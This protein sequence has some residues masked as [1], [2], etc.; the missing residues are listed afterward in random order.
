MREADDCPNYLRDFLNYI[1]IV[2]NLGERTTLAYYTDLRCFLRYLKIKNGLADESSKWEEISISDVPFE[3]VKAVDLYSAYTYLRWL[4]AKRNNS[5]ATRARKTT[6][7]REFYRY[8]TKK[9]HLLEKDPLEQLEMPAK[10]EKLPKFLTLE[11][12]KRLL[13][14]IESSSAERDFCIMVLFL[15][16][17]LRLSELCGL[18]IG[19]I[20]FDNK[21][22]R[23]LGKGNK[24]RI[25][26][27]NDAC[28]DSIRRYLEVRPESQT[29]ALFLSNRK[30]RLSRRRVQELTEKYVNAAGLGNRGISTHKLRHTAATLMYQHGGCDA[31]II[32]DILGHKSIATTEIYTHLANENIRG[33]MDSNPLAGVKIKTKKE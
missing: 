3:L 8:L 20:N 7:L 33:A 32:K 9:S 1:S 11:E 18:N 4:A 13:T 29:N 19:D 22:M 14:G 28:L 2:K 31:L 6:A 15:N 5:A 24:E 30:T 17:G 25:V 27:L 21:S 12:S 10:K 26:Y 23:V 16:C